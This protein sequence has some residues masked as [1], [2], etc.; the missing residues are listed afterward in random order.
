M[1]FD[2]PD[3]IE[4]ENDEGECGAFVNVPAPTDSDWIVDVTN[5]LMVQEILQIFI[6]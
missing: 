4:V 1:W 5:D 6:L 2:C 3:D